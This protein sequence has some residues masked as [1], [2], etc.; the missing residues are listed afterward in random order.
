[1]SRSKRDQRGK[2]INGEIWGHDCYQV[3]GGKVFADC[4][5][6]RIGAPNAKKGAK[7]HVS[8]LRRIED[9]AIIK[10]ET[11]SA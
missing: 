7:K 8:R 6:E 3:N 9:K 4:G 2:R 1:M 5:G 10:S 11:L